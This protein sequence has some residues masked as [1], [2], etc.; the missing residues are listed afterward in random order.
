M[1][2]HDLAALLGG[3]VEDV[4]RGDL[5]HAV[6]GVRQEGASGDVA[7]GPHVG[8]VG[9]H[10]VVDDDAA[11]DLEAG[12]F[13]APAHRR[14]T[15]ANGHEDHVGLDTQLLLAL[16]VVDGASVEG[17]D[18]AAQLEGHFLHGGA[19]LGGQVVVHEG[20]DL[21]G[22]LDDGH[23]GA[24]GGVQ[25]GELDADDA[26]ADDREASRDLGQREDARGVDQRGVV[27]GAGQRGHGR[28]GARGDDDVVRGVGCALDGHA[29]GG[30]EV[31]AAIDDGHARL[32]LG[33]CDAG[34]QALNYLVLPGLHLLPVDGHALRIHA[35][36]AGFLGVQV[37]LRAVEQGLGGDAAHVQAGTAQ[38]LLLNEGDL[39]ARVSE[40]LGSQVATGARTEDDDVK[41]RVTHEYSSFLRPE[42]SHRC[43]RWR[44]PGRAGSEHHPRRR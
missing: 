28:H 43:F 37:V 38:V 42:R 25:G 7:D 22:H 13:G 1:P 34:D 10:R 44:R 32:A 8:Q 17:L 2:A 5:R 27:L 31:A 30:V 4:R 20:Q 18:A 33:G 35:E 14:G 12:L 29:T 19:G 6:G 41:M 24:E 16:G 15:A 11:V 21:R 40:A 26:A 9:A 3:G 23:L 39:L 36:L